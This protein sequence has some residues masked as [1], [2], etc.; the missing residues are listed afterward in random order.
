MGQVQQATITQ[1]SS[2]MMPIGATAISVSESLCCCGVST[3]RSVSADSDTYLKLGAEDQEKRRAE[4]E[5]SLAGR[6][7][8]LF[9]AELAWLMLCSGNGRTANT[10]ACVWDLRIHNTPCSHWLVTPPHTLSLPSFFKNADGADHPHDG[11]WF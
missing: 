7:P 1:Y 5:R 3:T 8:E 10:T 4:G 9:E 2:Q 11:F 6:G